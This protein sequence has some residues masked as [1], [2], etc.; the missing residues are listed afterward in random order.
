MPHDLPLFIAIGL[1]GFLLPFLSRRAGRDDQARLAR[2]ED[3]VNLLLDKLGVE[4]DT[5]S[6]EVRDLVLEGKTISAIKA[7]RIQ[8]PGVGLMEAK[9]A[10]QAI[11]AQLKAE[12]FQ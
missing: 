6:E 1:Y 9:N 5:P 2:L 8:N 7:Y 12:S 10:I 11:K 4:H 3:K